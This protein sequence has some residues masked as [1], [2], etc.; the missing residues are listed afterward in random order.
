M[1]KADLT[2]RGEFDEIFKNLVRRVS[3]GP[4]LTIE[5]SDEEKRKRW[6]KQKSV[7]RKRLESQSRE[8]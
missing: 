7:V 4:K 8:K 1:K 2:Q 6:E 5:P 3:L